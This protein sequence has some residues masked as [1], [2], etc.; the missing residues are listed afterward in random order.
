MDSPQAIFTS[1]KLP[2]PSATPSSSREVE[3]ND[4]NDDR[5]STHS[6][7]VSTTPQCDPSSVLTVRFVF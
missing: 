7:N 2:K 5:S 4:S 6:P 1:F 3:Q